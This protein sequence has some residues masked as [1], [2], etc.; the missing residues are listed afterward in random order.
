MVIFLAFIRE[1][2]DLTAYRTEWI[3]YGEDERIAGC[4]D[5]VARDGRGR[6]VLFDWQRA[7]ACGTPS[8]SPNK[9][10]HA[11][12]QTHTRIPGRPPRAYMHAARSVLLSYDEW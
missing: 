9:T 4:I 11:H 7:K 2:Q 3:I 10:P 5:F 12:T 6:L 8:L 1:L